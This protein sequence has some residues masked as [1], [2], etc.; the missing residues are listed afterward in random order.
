[1]VGQLSF[2]KF[3]GGWEVRG[4][5]VVQVRKVFV[6]YNSKKLRIVISHDKA[7]MDRERPKIHLFMVDKGWMSF[8]FFI[9]S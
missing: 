4:I 1:M 9:G 7:I 3:I 6:L 2:D 8:F 5:R